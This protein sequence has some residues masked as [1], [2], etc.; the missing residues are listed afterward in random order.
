MNNMHLLLNSLVLG[1]TLVTW[2]TVATSQAD[3]ATPD[4]KGREIMSK[5]IAR[6]DGFGDFRS[7]VELTITDEK[8]NSRVR[9]M[10]VSDL[11]ISGGGEKRLFV[12]D[13]PMDVQGTA[14]LSHTRAN[15][16]KQWIFL[17]AFKRV[18][19]IASANKSTPFVGSE[20]SYEDLASVELEKYQYRYI[21]T[22]NAS[23]CDCY[24]VEMRPVDGNSGYQKQMAYVDSKE[25]IFRRVEYYDRN[26]DLLKSLELENYQL[27]IDRYWRPLRLNMVNH[28]N[29]RKS[30]MIWSDVKYRNG[31]SDNDL[32]VAALNRV[33]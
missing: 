29:N 4:S 27:F 6:D 17:P 8:G 14:V 9:K 13:Y 33:R 28:R 24:V 3:N 7:N 16:E 12:F 2:L 19:R 21:K 26:G 18:K 22:E 23:R 15:D 20:F 10:Q 25:Y 11:E 1:V 32:S 31:V 30:V 5:V